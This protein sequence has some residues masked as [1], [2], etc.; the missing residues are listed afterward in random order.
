MI[1]EALF[2]DRPE[3]AGYRRVEAESPEAA[4]ILE[5]SALYYARSM[6][7]EHV[8]MDGTLLRDLW[9]PEERETFAAAHPEAWEQAADERR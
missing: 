5:Q 4:A 2:P 7:S 9:T 8:M 1:G 6:Q 3:M